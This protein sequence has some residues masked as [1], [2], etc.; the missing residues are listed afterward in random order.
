MMFPSRRRAAR[1]REGAVGVEGVAMGRRDAARGFDRAERFGSLRS[2][3][4]F[5]LLAA[6]VAQRPRRDVRLTLPRSTIGEGRP[7]R[8]SLNDQ[9]E[10]PGVSAQLAGRNS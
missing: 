3:S 4:A 1:V 7:L 6:L 2:L 5:R 10:Q 9:D 8:S